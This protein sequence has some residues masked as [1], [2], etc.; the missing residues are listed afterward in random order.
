[1]KK[2]LSLLLLLSLSSVAFASEAH[3]PAPAPE[4]EAV[5]EEEEEFYDEE[6]EEEELFE[7]KGFLTTEDCA[8]EGSFK[9]CYSESYVCGFQGCFEEVDPGEIRPVQLVIFVHD[10]WKYY[11]VDLSGNLDR[12][13]LD[14][15]I[16]R[17]EV[18]I[19][20]NYNEADNTIV[21]TEF[22]APP[23]PKKSFFKG[24]L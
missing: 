13:T 1:M 11:K 4:T 23:P 6:E 7:K 18:T 22:K 16:G 20:G 24:C 19:I 17:N 21:A 12:A 9:D 15:G 8:V 2:L 14:A 5:A 3:H 10:D